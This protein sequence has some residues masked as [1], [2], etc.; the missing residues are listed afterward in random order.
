M[1]TKNKEKNVPYGAREKMPLWYSLAWSSRGI[2]AALNVILIGYVSFYASD[3][4]GLNIGIIGTLLLVSKVV[5]AFTDLGMGYLID[6]THTKWGKARPYEIFIVLMWVFTV[7]LFSTPDIGAMGQYIYIFIMYVM[8]NA[9]C[10]TALGGADSVYMAR[11]FATDNNRIKAMSVNGVV[12]MFCCIVFNIIAPQFI[13]NAGV[14]KSG[15]AMLAIGMGV[16]L[17]IIGMLRFILCKEIPIPSEVEKEQTKDKEESKSFKE[18]VG[19]LLKNKYV[20]IIIGLMLITNIINGVGPAATYYFKYQV[21][22]I[23]ALSLANMTALITPLLLIV[24]PLLSRKL[25]TTKILQ[26]ATIFG[27]VG[28]LIR[29]FGGTNMATII[30]GGG[31]AS[32]AVL[33]I[34]MMINT[35]LIDCMDYGE[36]KTGVRVE[37]LVASTA[38]FA[39]KLGSGI[40][41]GFLGLIMG[42]AGYNGALTVQSDAANMAIVG[43]YNIFPLVLYVV[44]FVLSL[45]YKM[46]KD[47]PQMQADLKKKHE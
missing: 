14:S 35:Y 30:I 38:N 24:F 12:V 6:K 22:N 3:V 10:T 11:T 46:D 1:N 15:W 19:L 36:W 32:V 33:P 13:N 34:S 27:I 20:F 37:G 47:R 40:A 42:L 44:M 29:T 18:T 2:S 45:M 17:S 43:M 4:L 28:I 5:D 31:I 9:V 39:G 8:I 26:A 7:L 25:G 41:A 16:P 21:G 23:G